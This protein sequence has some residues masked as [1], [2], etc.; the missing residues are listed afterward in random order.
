[1]LGA[2]DFEIHFALG[3]SLDLS[4]KHFIDVLSTCV[5]LRADLD[6]KLAEQEARVEPLLK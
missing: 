6:V 1:M 2:E 3:Q 4:L 5:F